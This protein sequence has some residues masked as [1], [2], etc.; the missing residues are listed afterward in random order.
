M[1]NKYR[2]TCH[3]CGTAV[4]PRRGSLHKQ[5]RKWL[6]TC[7]G[8]QSG[9][10]GPM[11][12]DRAMELANADEEQAAGIYASSKSAGREYQSWGAY[13]PG[14]GEYIYQNK[15]GRCEDAPCCGCCS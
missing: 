13:F 1:Q 10:E 7:Q 9:N 5:G 2:G 12:I 8:C 14:S 4:A 3:K 11:T 6:V 15:A